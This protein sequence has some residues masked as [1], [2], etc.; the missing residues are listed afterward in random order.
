MTVLP[1]ASFFKI[2]KEEEASPETMTPAKDK[3]GKGFSSAWPQV[4]PGRQKEVKISNKNP[5]KMEE[6]KQNRA[7]Q[8]NFG[9]LIVINFIF[10]PRRDKTFFA[11][12][13]SPDVIKNFIP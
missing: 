11:D 6:R 2:A 13:C 7:L 5:K 9:L 8:R 12:R 3:G 4:N 10:H 1:L